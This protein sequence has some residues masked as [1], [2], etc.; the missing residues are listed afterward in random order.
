MSTEKMFLIEG[1][2]SDKIEI[3]YAS[4]VTELIREKFEED[5]SGKE[6]NK[7]DETQTFF[8]LWAV[9]LVEKRIVYNPDTKVKSINIW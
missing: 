3:R 8:E 4:N 1:K 9:Y 2:F 7:D 6:F 5:N